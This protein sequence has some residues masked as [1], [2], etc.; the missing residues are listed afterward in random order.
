MGGSGGGGGGAGAWAGL[1]AAPGG[2]DEPPPPALLG[3]TQLQEAVRCLAALP[4]GEVL[5]LAYSGRLQSLR[6]TLAE[7]GGGSAEA[8]VAA[9]RSAD[10]VVARSEAL[11]ALRAE[12]EALRLAVSSR[13]GAAEASGASRATAGGAPPPPPHSFPLQHRLDASHAWALDAADGAYTLTLELP[14]PISSVLLSSTTMVEAPDSLTQTLAALPVPLHPAPLG[15]AWGSGA[16]GE[17]GGSSGASSSTAGGIASSGGVMI[18]RMPPPLP[19]AD[20]F[21]GLA[22]GALPSGAASPALLL[23]LRAPLTFAVVMTH[24]FAAVAARP[25]APPQA[26]QAGKA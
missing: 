10:E 13:S 16:G 8:G 9:A 20:A 15:Q 7:G 18:S 11:A 25:A 22:D 6:L 12:V 23:A 5:A 14:C 1:D 21:R 24:L 3:A 19:I 4:G 2:G 26:S 17:A